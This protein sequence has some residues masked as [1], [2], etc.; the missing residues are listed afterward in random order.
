NA[1][2]ETA[3][4][5]DGRHT[6]INF[7]RG[8]AVQRTISPCLYIPSLSLLRFCHASP[9]MSFIVAPIPAPH[10]ARN[11]ANITAQKPDLL[12]ADSGTH[13]HHCRT[14]PCRSG[15]RLYPVGGWIDPTCQTDWRS[16]GRTGDLHRTQIWWTAECYARQR[17]RT[18]HHHLCY[19]GRLT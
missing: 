18:D 6:R 3:T 7:S 10:S 8:K 16:N 11:Y 12:P 5:L 19:S 1:V 14:F 13:C 4:R 17:R 15:H 2:G 9:I